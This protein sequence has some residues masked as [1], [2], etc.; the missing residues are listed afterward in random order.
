MVVGLRM[1]HVVFRVAVVLRRVRVQILHQRMEAQLAKA[2]AR[3]LVMH[4]N[5]QLMEV[6]LVGQFVA[7]E[8]NLVHVQILHQL[9]V[10]LR[11]LVPH[12]NRVE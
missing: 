2:Q 6:G 11:V 12:R 7:A 8:T 5:V 1:E 9:M 4:K 10:E 3:K